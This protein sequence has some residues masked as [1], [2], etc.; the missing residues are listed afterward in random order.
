M[1]EIV[2][3]PGNGEMRKILLCRL[4]RH[5]THFLYCRLSF[6]LFQLVDHPGADPENI[7]GANGTMFFSTPVNI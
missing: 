1:C 7:W 3:D 2:A 5:V 6:I 4:Y